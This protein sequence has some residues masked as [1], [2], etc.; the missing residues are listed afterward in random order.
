MKKNELALHVSPH[1]NTVSCNVC[2]WL[3]FLCSGKGV[4][5]KSLI[6]C[7]KTN[8]CNCSGYFHASLPLLIIWQVHQLTI[9]FMFVQMWAECLKSTE[10]TF[11]FRW[12]FH[13]FSTHLI[14]FLF[15]FS[16]FYP[17]FSHSKWQITSMCVA[18]FTKRCKLTKT[19]T[20]TRTKWLQIKIAFSLHFNL[21]TTIRSVF[22]HDDVHFI[23]FS[24]YHKC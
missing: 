5:Y 14:F 13:C 22:A 23:S 21:M 1:S 12:F 17:L 18:I 24:R 19:H 9:F 11:S 8:G 7:V 15:S 6:D 4:V 20:H 3:W 10:L 2:N 16:S